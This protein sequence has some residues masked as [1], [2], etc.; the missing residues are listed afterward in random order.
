MRA[1]GAVLLLSAAL[2]TPTSPTPPTGPAGATSTAVPTS[3]AT[4][5]STA[6]PTARLGCLLPPCGAVENRTPTRITVRWADYGNGWSYG[7]VPPWGRMG[8]WWHDRIDV[9]YF[10]IA[11]GC[12]ATT[13]GW[14]SSFGPG[15]YKIGSDETVVLNGHTCS[16]APAAAR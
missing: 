4:P 7:A 14:V 11:P 1:L 5:T 16:T 10:L 6:V 12:R 3:T 9:D 15:W 8:G 13:S 2:T